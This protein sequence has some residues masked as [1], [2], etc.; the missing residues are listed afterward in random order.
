M[1][2]T[3]EGGVFMNGE[4]Q[5]K[6]LNYALFFL[7]NEIKALK[8]TLKSVDDP[9]TTPL[10]EKRLMELERDFE[11]FLELENIHV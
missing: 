5:R 8:E 4:Q 10:L 2:A 3:K 11:M 9:L 1:E 7:R 6:A